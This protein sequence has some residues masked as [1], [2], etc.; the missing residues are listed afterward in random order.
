ME[1]ESEGVGRLISSLDP[2]SFVTMRKREII[3]EIILF[4]YLF[5]FTTP[6]VLEK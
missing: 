1:E 5:G 4:A 3:Q 2:R 6:N